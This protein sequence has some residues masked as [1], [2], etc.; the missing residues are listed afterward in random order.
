[1]YESFREKMSGLRAFFVI[2][3]FAVSLV[4]CEI[5]CRNEAGDPVDWFVVYKLPQHQINETHGSGLDYLYLD[6]K[7]QGWQ[8]SKFLINTTEGAVGRVL[9]QLYR[10]YNRNDSGY[11]LYNDSPPGMNSSF[12]RG[13]SKG[14]LLFDSYQG[15]W[16]VHTVPHFP[17]FPGD[18]FGY[19]NTGRLYGQVALC[20]TYKYNQF[21]Q[22]AA[23]LL[24]YNPNVYN[25]SLPGIWQEDL[26]GL[27]RICQGL[28]FPWIETTR[29]ASLQSAQGESFLNFAK[30]KYFQDDI[31]VAWMAQKLETDLLTE[32][33]Q[34]TK[35]V[36]QSN[37]TLPW[38]VYTIRKIK[39]PTGSFYSRS[40]HSK[41][42]VSRWSRD[43]WTCIGDLNRYPEQLWRSGGFICTQNRLLYK[44]FRNI[45]AFYSDCKKDRRN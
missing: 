9:Q 21:K 25:C 12:T 1:M 17:P 36:V 15:F 45:V 10:S 2:C 22:I 11:L 16:L 28:R 35:V 42:C 37:C 38:H 31:F 32:T 14:V 24:Y 30:S 7:T 41:W 34:P 27:Y 3:M 19:P 8:V 43:G 13:H 6:S 29:L 44:A 23:Q 33:W 26:W 39:L 40:D 20:V 5:A 18:G 4:T